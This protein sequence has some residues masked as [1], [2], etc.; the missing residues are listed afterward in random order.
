MARKQSARLV[1]GLLLVMAV[2][3][4]AGSF[5]STAGM[6]ALP[7]L[8]SDSPGIAHPAHMHQGTCATGGEFLVLLSDAVPAIDLAGGSPAQDAVL[9]LSTAI[10]V[11]R[12]TSTIP[13]ALTDLL[14]NPVSI[15]L[16]ESALEPA[17][18]IAC[19]DIGGM[20]T[21]TELLV[22]LAPIEPQGVP[23]VA[24]LRAD[25]QTTRVTIFLIEGLSLAAAAPE[26]ADA[27]TDASAETVTVT[28]G[29][30]TGEF[31][32]STSQT[33]FRVGV[34]YHFVVT[35]SGVIPHEFLILPAGLAGGESQDTEQ[36]HH[37]ALAT[38]DEE[39]L[40]SGATVTI[41]VTF[42]DAAPMGETEFVCALAGH[43]DG[44]M[45]L[46]IEIVS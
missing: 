31:T 22:G 42:T 6:A 10:P 2:A 40:P 9:G 25:G 32:I 20:T 13:I 43:Y 37:V 8:Q 30:P 33:T 38:I 36:I 28:L 12:S 1:A 11:T 15:E 18:V 17:D 4:L 34:P 3:P 24:W 14:A 5:Q 44:G 39:S 19:G 46:P 26:A 35:N 21:G 27:T 41:D 45:H 29:G 16:H 23:G 7:P